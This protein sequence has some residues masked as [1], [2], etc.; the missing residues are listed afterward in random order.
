MHNQSTTRGRDEEVSGY[1][2]VALANCGTTP[3]SRAVD[4]ADWNWLPINDSDPRAVAIYRRHYSVDLKRNHRSGIGGP[5]ER[6]VLLTSGCDALWVWRR[7]PDGLPLNVRGYDDGQRGVMCSVFRNESTIR[8]SDLIQEAMGLAWQRW[9]GVRLFTYVK[10][11]AIRST[12]PGYCFKVAGW[13][14]CG[15]SKGG[16]VILEAVP[17]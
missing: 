1:Q 15:V 8:S 4:F 12:N 5:G 17:Q 13:K 7:R 14:K 3:D 10:G 16:L 11:S 2:Q 6:M 9:P